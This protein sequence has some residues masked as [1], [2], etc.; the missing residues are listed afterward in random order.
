MELVDSGVELIYIRDLLG[1]A[2]IKTTEIYAR[3][4]S[5]KKREA[6]EA[7]S[8]DIVS[9]EEAQWENNIRLKDWLKNFNRR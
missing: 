7:A 4:D 2:S 5:A 6:I 3:T 9:R 1:H 8:K